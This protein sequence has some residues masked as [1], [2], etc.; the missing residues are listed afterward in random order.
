MFGEESKLWSSSVSSYLQTSVI[1]I[2]LERREGTDC[3]ISSAFGIVRRFRV[4]Y[5]HV[6]IIVNKK[7]SIVS[8]NIP[9]LN[10][11]IYSEVYTIYEKKV[12]EVKKY[13]TN[14]QMYLFHNQLIT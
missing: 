3:Y 11:I 7:K 9:S 2:L 13:V 8:E 12:T 14:S 4:I 1:P 6:L 5:F 10:T